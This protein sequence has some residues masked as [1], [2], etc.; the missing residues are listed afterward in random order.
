[1][2]LRPGGFA[3]TVG[4]PPTPGQGGRW[5]WPWRPRQGGRWGWRPARPPCIPRLPLHQQ[6][7]GRDEEDR[8]DLQ[9]APCPSLRDGTRGA[10]T[11]P[12]LPFVCA[13]IV[14]GFFTPWGEPGDARG[15]RGAPAPSAPLPGCGR[16]AHR[17]HEAPGRSPSSPCRGHG[18]DPHTRD[19]SQGPQ[20]R[21][22]IRSSGLILI[23]SGLVAR[24]GGNPRR[25][26]RSC[27][28]AGNR[29]WFHASRR[30]G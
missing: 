21:R 17:S 11:S 13:Q 25:S 29:G 26:R 23:D 4:C 8:F 18:S 20:A 6:A 15:P 2:G 16:A 14:S 22:A 5:G 3:G 10:R 12:S 19:F 1:M 28:E 24:P 9:N 27:Q 30:T 7:S